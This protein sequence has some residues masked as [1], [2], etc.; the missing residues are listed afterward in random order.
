MKLFSTSCETKFLGWD[1]P[2]LP[3]AATTLRQRYAQGD[4]LDLSGFI[5]V[6][7]TSHSA[8]QMS[9]RLRAAA[10]SDQL[11]YQPPK[12]I[13]VGQ[14]AEQLYEPPHR[15]ALELEQTLAWAQVLRNFSPDELQPLLPVIPAPEPVGPWMEIAGAINR[16]HQELSTS[17]FTFHDVIELA[18]TEIEQRRWKLL[19]K[20]YNA[21]LASLKTAG[22]CDPYAARQDAVLH[23]RCRCDQTIVLIGTSDLSEA[24]IAML[25]SLENNLIALVAAPASESNRFDELGCVDTSHWLNQHLPLQDHHLIAAQDMADQ[26][27]TVAEVLAELAGDYT[28]SEVTVGVTDES[29]VGPIEMELRC[30]GVTPHRHLGWTVAET[31]IGRLLDLVSAHLAR[32]TWSTLAALVRHA[33]VSGYVSRHLGIQPTEW[34]K[35]LDQLLSEFF[36]I[37]VADPLSKPAVKKC[38]LAQPVAKLIGEWLLPLTE[39]ERSIADWSGIVAAWLLDLFPLEMDDLPA[40]ETDNR[41]AFEKSTLHDRTHLAMVATQRLLKRYAELNDQLD[42]AVGGAT[43]VEML[44]ARLADVRIAEPKHEDDLS[45]LGWLDLALDDA[46]LLVVNGLNHPFVPSGIT[47]DPFLPGTLR[48]RLRMEDH[49]RR[50]ARDAYA[51]HLMITTRPA[52]RFIVGSTAADLSP[53]PPSRLLA[54]APGIDIARRIRKLLGQQRPA[55]PVNHQWDTHS[56]DQRLPIPE[57]PIKQGRP[58]VTSMSVTAFAD[59]LRC[60]YRF[61]LRHVLKFK[62]LD[63]EANELAANQFGNLVHAALEEFGL[64][65][66]R[67]EG[68]ADK[69]EAMLGSHLNHYAAEYYGKSVSTAVQLQIAQAQRRFKAVARQQALRIAE[70]WRIH[71][72]EASV[73]ERDGAFI[74]VDNQKMGLRGRFDR[75]DHHPGTGQWAI[76]DYKTHGYRPEKKHL[77]KTDDG[78]RWIDLQL[79]LYRLMIPY[80]GIDAVPAEVQLGYFNVSEKEEETRINIAGFTPD[81]MRQAEEVIRDCVAGI[82]AG[83]FQPASDRIQYDD[84]GMILQTSVANRLLDQ[85]EWLSATELES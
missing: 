10:E 76:L 18:E 33:D 62:P 56:S 82:W 43:A 49:N 30:C 39:H 15:I 17:Q 37:R 16:L 84:Y 48:N 61:Y 11:Q 50:Y 35:E 58:A 71:A 68:D 13:T 7:P 22:L 38:P 81:Q 4:H 75:I 19:N 8:S 25:R 59:Y 79:P 60:P 64:S 45:I 9:E 23:N 31:S 29:H 40:E 2:L 28:T 20:I 12:I 46:K 57:L 78:Y 52:V 55:A 21:Y 51:M 6:L 32:G 66:D 26:A 85:V 80:L 36:P 65:D 47:S 27:Q 72:T 74:E 77:K 67:D 3:V 70:G 73:S 42:L 41:E 63:D 54:S 34:L 14:L 1:A 44:S 83:N 53:T 24:L 69:I 5:L